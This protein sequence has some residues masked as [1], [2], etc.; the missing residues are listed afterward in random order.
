M[1]PGPIATDAVVIGAGPAGLFQ[2][3]YL[4]LLGISC[5]IV[6]VLP[7]PGGQCAELYGD[8]P[9]YDIAAVPACTGD[10]LVARLL[11]QLRPFDPPM[12]LGQ[13][14]TAL[15]P[16]AD[17]AGFALLTSAG[18]AFHARSVFIAGGVGAFAPRRLKAPGLE[19]F[20]GTDQLVYETQFPP[21]LS[22]DAPAPPG[23]AAWAGR[24]VVVAG[25]DASAIDRAL[26]LAALPPDHRPASVTLLHRRSVLQADAPRLAAFGRQLA[27]SAVR[28]VVGQVISAQAAADGR[29]QAI[30]VRGPDAS[31]T[32]MPLDVLIVALGVSPRLGPL[33]DWGLALSHKQVPV[34]TECFATVVPGIYAVGDINTYPGKKRLIV[35]AFHEA[36]L[37]AFAAAERLYPERRTALQY[38]TSSSELQQRLGVAPTPP[39]T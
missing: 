33:A 14:V 15:S 38:T 29:L 23:A 11:E 34:D 35:S 20:E 6:D 22:P 3:F 27:E 5:H 32:C 37:A 9:I 31:E 1:S 36:T 39:S 17:D 18:Q 21:R 25:G 7:R 16:L 2:A 24:A 26:T 10:E 8:K 30:T 28:L 12:H 19:A 4:G 13:E